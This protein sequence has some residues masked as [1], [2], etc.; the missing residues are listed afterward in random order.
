MGANGNPGKMKRV[1][2]VALRDKIVV[3]PIGWQ[4]FG[5]EDENQVLPT[6]LHTWKIGFSSKFEISPRQGGL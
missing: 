3:R 1:L 6:Q 4:I 5:V 2:A